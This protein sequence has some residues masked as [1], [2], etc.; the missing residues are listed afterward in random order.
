VR[1]KSYLLYL[2]VLIILAG[3]PACRPK[4]TELPFETIIRGDGATY[5]GSKPLAILV[6]DRQDIEKMKDLFYQDVL[7]EI[8][9][10]D[11]GR[12][13]V[14]AVLRSLQ[15]TSGYDTVIDHVVR[16]G[17]KIVVYAQFW[18]PGRDQV[19]HETITSP[20]HIIKVPKDNGVTQ[21]IE[22]VLQTWTVTRTPWSP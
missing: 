7:D 3:T 19:V 14:I 10:V 20:Y 5:P 1:R 16:R 22:L 18:E 6:T 9:T 2:I 4:E 12:Y 11:F 21:E 15:G 13:F 8:A 17:E